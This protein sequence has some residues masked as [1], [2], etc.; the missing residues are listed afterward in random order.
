[1]KIARRVRAAAT[2]AALA[3]A[4]AARAATP[5]MDDLTDLWFKPN[6]SG[7]GVNL[8]QQG[9]I[10]FA[11][12]FVYDITGK[13]HWFVA[14]SMVAAPVPS[15]RPVLFTGDLFETTGPAFSAPAFN[16][17]SVTVRR[18]GTAT[19]E[20]TP[21]NSGHLTY[22][23][24]G[25]SV[26]KDVERQAWAQ[27]DLSGQYYGAR[28]TQ[29]SPTT[30]GCS[31]RVGTQ[32]FDAIDLAHLG[33]S[34]AITATHGSPVDESCR[35]TGSYVQN[36][37]VGSV[38][39]TYTCNSGANGTFTLRNLEGGRHGFAAAYTAT[40]RTCRVVGNFSAQRKN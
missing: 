36:G 7:W 40:D 33:G 29:L 32:V 28:V 24:D 4:L 1:M 11:T 8:I 3:A 14:S 35:Y 13:A 19:F 16:P 17:A 27:N 20:F 15:D 23:V 22:T 34:I 18:V 12:L 9:N 21:P 25:V 5:S 6:E 31:T 26:A 39:G 10:V 2:A 38:D 30:P 37:H